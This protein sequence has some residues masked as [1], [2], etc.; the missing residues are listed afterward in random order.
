MD[1]LDSRSLQ[2]L[3][4]DLAL[5]IA[6]KKANEQIGARKT[7]RTTVQSD[8]IPELHQFASDKGIRRERARLLD[9]F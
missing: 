5:L 2:N 3:V 8:E 9:A 7:E 6:L 1:D 4:D